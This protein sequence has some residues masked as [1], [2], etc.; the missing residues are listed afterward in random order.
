MLQMI[1]TMEESK[2]P[3][4]SSNYF[5]E[6]YEEALKDIEMLQMEKKMF[7]DE[8]KKRD[9]L[10]R[11]QDVKLQQKDLDLA[12]MATVIQNSGDEMQAMM[13][14][15]GV[16]CGEEAEEEEVEDKLIRLIQKTASLARDGAI[17]Y[18]RK[19]PDQYDASELE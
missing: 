1:Q 9:A 3:S 10:I 18:L 19:Q 15:L 4:Q 2:V 14:R 11:E 12:Q 13:N 5:K 8:M 17:S 6:K 16:P 7:F